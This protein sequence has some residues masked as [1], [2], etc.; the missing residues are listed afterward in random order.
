MALVIPPKTLRQRLRRYAPF[1][2][3]LLWIDH[4]DPAGWILTIRD[5]N[6]I[7]MKPSKYSISLSYAGVDK[8]RHDG[9][10]FTFTWVLGKH[11]GF[12]PFGGH[13]RWGS[14]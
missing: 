10:P 2:I 11:A 13:S 12:C 4:V 9:N 7:T 1:H 5:V 14:A 3:S 6:P 8:Y